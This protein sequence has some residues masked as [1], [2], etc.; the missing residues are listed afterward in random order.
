MPGGQTA[1]VVGGGER[2]TMWGSNPARAMESRLTEGALFERW[3]QGEER[4]WGDGGKEKQGK[5]RLKQNITN[6][7]NGKADDND[8]T[9]TV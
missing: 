1:N 7:L 4:G 5:G 9:A 3:C 6:S 8:D 2:V